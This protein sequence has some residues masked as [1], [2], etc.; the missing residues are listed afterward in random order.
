M[1]DLA[2]SLTAMV[3]F[4]FNEQG[5]DNC[6]YVSFIYNIVHLASHLLMVLPI[7]PCLLKSRSI[8]KARRQ[9][10]KTLIMSKWRMPLF[11]VL[12]TLTNI[13]CLY[14]IIVELFNW[15]NYTYLFTVFCLLGSSLSTVCTYVRIKLDC[16]LFY[17][18]ETYKFF[19]LAVASILY[20][21]S[22]HEYSLS[23]PLL[24]M[25]WAYFL[26]RSKQSLP[27]HIVYYLI[28]FMDSVILLTAIL[29][30]SS[31]QITQRS[32]SQYH[33]FN[34]SKFGLVFPLVF[35]GILLAFE[36]IDFISIYNSLSTSYMGKSED[37]VVEF[38]TQMHQF[39]TKSIQCQGK[40]KIPAEDCSICLENFK[41]SKERLI[42]NCHHS[43]HQ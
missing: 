33:I 14:S 39:Q 9:Y 13:C 3:Y 12:I 40:E 17:S 24:G 16:S 10:M 42:L 35:F 43:F 19:C 29:V 26:F 31:S 25:S 4:S 38:Y 11:A 41:H 8:A 7:L 37:S 2:F 1:L 23:A 28:L 36:V 34:N 22:A 15:Y 6:F 18:L 20:G 30:M 27:K 5:Y 21:I 32:T